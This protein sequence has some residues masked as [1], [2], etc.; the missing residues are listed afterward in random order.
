MDDDDDDDDG[1]DTWE[2]Y[3]DDAIHKFE[4]SDYDPEIHGRSTD[5]GSSDF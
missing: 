3:I 5:F 4:Y 1:S 2:D